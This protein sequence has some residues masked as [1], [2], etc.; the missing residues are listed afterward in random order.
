MPRAHRHYI[1]GYVW[2]ITHRCH[3]REFLFKFA[4]DRRRWIG[5]LFEAKKRYGLCILN[6]MATSNH[7]HLLILDNGDRNTVPRSLQL[8]AGRTGQQYNQRRNR[9]GAFWQD[10]YHATAI[11][12]DEHLVRCIQYIDM[13]MVRTG[14]VQEPGQWPFCGYSEIQNAKKRYRIIDVQKLMVLLQVRDMVELQVLCRKRAEEA[15]ACQRLVR[16]SKWTESIAVGSEGF[17]EATKKKLG[18]RGKGR[19]VVGYEGSYHLREPEVAYTCDFTPENDVL[20]HEN[21]YFWD[22]I[23]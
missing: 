17:V 13:N 19:R 3:K 4:R 16:E 5:W 15:L 11:E 12:C 8:I 10:R 20:R 22:N 18:L 21:T 1:P 14:V 23:L 6:Y 2:H 7:I 9:K